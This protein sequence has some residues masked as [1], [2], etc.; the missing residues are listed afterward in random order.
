MEMFKK[1]LPKEQDNGKLG[2]YPV[3]NDEEW[4]NLP[5][6]YKAMEWFPIEVY[7]REW[8]IKETVTVG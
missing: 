3:M 4:E 1:F 6:V 7:N 5:V 8:K 2:Y